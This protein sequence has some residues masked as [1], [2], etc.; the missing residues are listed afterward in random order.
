MRWS[1]G[2]R[3]P[4]LDLGGKEAREAQQFGESLDTEVGDVGLMSPVKKSGRWALDFG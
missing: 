2:S 1:G 3:A 4:K